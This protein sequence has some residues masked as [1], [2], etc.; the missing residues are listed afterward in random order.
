M[1]PALILVMFAALAWRRLARQE[2]PEAQS[3]AP[4]PAAGETVEQGGIS[5][6][7]AGPTGTLRIQP[8]L[9]DLDATVRSRVEAFLAQLEAEGFAPLPYEVGRLDAEQARLYAQGRTAPGKIVTNLAVPGAHR[10]PAAWGLDIVDGRKGPS[11]RIY[12]WGHP[13]GEGAPGVFYRRMAELAPQHGLRSL[14]PTSLGD[15]VHIE[16]Q[17]GRRPDPVA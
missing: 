15:W 11:G 10:L 12:G 16:A 5:Y 4:P 6:V 1:V 13:D 2:A 7:L 17:E 14:G 3:S 9:E 8:R